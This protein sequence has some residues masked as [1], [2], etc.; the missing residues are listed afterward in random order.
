MKGGISK[1]FRH[2]F[3]LPQLDVFQSWQT[4]GFGG[5]W[6][7][8]P[9]GLFPAL[10]GCESTCVTWPRTASS[11]KLSPP[12]H[13]CLSTSLTP[14][15]PLQQPY[16]Q[17]ATQSYQ[18]ISSMVSTPPHTHTISA[19]NNLNPGLANLP[20]RLVCSETSCG[21]SELSKTKA[22]ILSC[23]EIYFLQHEVQAS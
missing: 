3:K 14:D 2:I 15:Y 5:E 21:G 8:D 23:L 17:S 22:M 19:L 1:T 4:G 18:F 11:R 9:K 10:F 12:R 20:L 6:V 7:P 13:L 16:M